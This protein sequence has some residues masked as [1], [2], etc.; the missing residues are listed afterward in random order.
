MLKKGFGA[1]Q[2][3][4]TDGRINIYSK[5]TR[6]KQKQDADGTI[7]KH[8]ILPDKR[9]DHLPRSQHRTCPLSPGHLDGP[10]VYILPS[11]RQAVGLVSKHRD[12]TYLSNIK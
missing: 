2:L 5:P 9:L 4:R 10:S 12:N 1:D 8:P 11:T 3:I 6:Y 7:F